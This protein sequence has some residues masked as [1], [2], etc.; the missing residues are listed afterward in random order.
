MEVA[1]NSTLGFSS[2]QF[3][4]IRSRYDR[5]DAVS[6][7]IHLSGLDITESLG[8]KAADIQDIGMPPT[9]MPGYVREK[10]KGCFRAHAN[11]W[12]ARLRKNLP[13]ALIVESDA[14]WDVNVRD[15]M[16]SF[17]HAERETRLRGKEQKKGIEY[18]PKDPW[19]SQHWDVLSLGHCFELPQ[20][21]DV[22]L[23][24]P[25][26]HVPPAWTTGVLAWATRECQTGAA[27][28]LLRSAVNLDDSVDMIMRLMILAGDL[29]A[30]STP[31]PHHGPVAA[32]DEDAQIEGVTELLT[33]FEASE[34]LLIEW[35]TSLLQSLGVPL[36]ST[37]DLFFLIPDNQLQTAHDIGA[38]LGFCPADKQQL[39]PVYPSEFSGRGIRYIIDDSDDES[40]AIAY[41]LFDMSYEGDYVELPSNDEPLSDKELEEMEKALE[42]IRSWVWRNDEEW[43]GEALLQVVAGKAR[44]DDLPH[45]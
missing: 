10:E 8:V 13:A 31:P 25:D 34:L 27:K 18:D 43:M 6:L 24:F 12:S 38:R 45:S 32:I 37:G 42:E 9:H 3:I 17:N 15:I 14:T 4:N 5:L 35:E 40:P 28:L 20:D 44:Y 23:A 33:R 21:N 19:L 22:Y 30:Y 41:R 29:V 16:A 1:G 2:I 36:V 39:P 7:Q 11:I 26:A